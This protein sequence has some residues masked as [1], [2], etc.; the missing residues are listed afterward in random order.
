MSP[1]LPAHSLPGSL[2]ETENLPACGSA[3]E[4]VSVHATMHAVCTQLRLYTHAP[5]RAYAHLPCTRMHLGEHARSYLYTHAHR[6]ACAHLPR[7]RM[8]IGEHACIAP[9]WLAQLHARPARGM[10]RRGKAMWLLAARCSD[11]YLASAGSGRDV[12]TSHNQLVCRYLGRD[13]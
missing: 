12:H 4:H 7:A 8:R 3:S 10:C 9:C 5:R 2:A 13:A 1:G 11:L 6:R